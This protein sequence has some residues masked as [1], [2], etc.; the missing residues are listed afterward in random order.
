M[1]FDFEG[2]DIQF[3][4]GIINESIGLLS[5]YLDIKSFNRES[6]KAM[7][8]RKAKGFIPDQNGHDI[9]CYSNHVLEVISQP[10]F[11]VIVNAA[12]NKIKGL[13][14]SCSYEEL[15]THICEIILRVNSEFIYRVNRIEESARPRGKRPD[16]SYNTGNAGP[17]FD[18]KIITKK[19]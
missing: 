16:Y 18:F 3:K 8:Y 11:Q 9:F 19:I 6:Q 10:S 17:N 4:K 2:L 12:I 15:E 13:D 7:D 14:L 5:S 1:N